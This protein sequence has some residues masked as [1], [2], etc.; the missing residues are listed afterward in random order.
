MKLTIAFLSSH[1]LYNQKVRAKMPI[2][3]RI[4]ILR[5]IK[6]KDIPCK[7]LVHKRYHRTGLPYWGNWG[8]PPLH[9]K[10]ACPLHID[11]VI[12]MLCLAILLKLFPKKSTPFGKPCRKP[13]KLRKMDKQVKYCIG[14]LVK[15]YHHF[16]R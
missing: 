11:F 8:Y 2:S 15:R 7:Y 4:E 13:W 10:L 14:G 1:F 12:F 16:P 5:W 6:W 9:E 3:Q